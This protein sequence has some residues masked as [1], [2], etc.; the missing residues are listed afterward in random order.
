V[1]IPLRNGSLGIVTDSPEKTR[2]V[3]DLLKQCVTW[4]G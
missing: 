1:V 2:K 4:E 3:E